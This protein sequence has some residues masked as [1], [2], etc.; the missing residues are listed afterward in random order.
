MNVYTSIPESLNTSNSVI[1]MGGFDGVH[2]GHQCIIQLMKKK[3]SAIQ[4]ETIVITFEPHPRLVLEPNDTDFKLLTIQEEKIELF[5]QHGID[6]LIFLPF[7]KEFAQTSSKEFVQ[8]ILVDKLQVKELVIGFNHRF[9]IYREGNFN[10]LVDFGKQFGFNVSEVTACQIESNTI[11]STKI[12]K[13]IN[14]SEIEKTNT[15]L[16]YPYFITGRVVLGNQ[17]GRG[18]NYPTANIKVNPLKLIPSTGVYASRTEINGILY[19]SMTYIGTRPT[20]D[21]K[22]P[23]I[24]THIFDFNED[25][26]GKDIKI[27]FLT[28]T[29]NQIRFNNTD[30]LKIQLEKDKIQILALL[31]T[32]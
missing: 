26:Y 18:L 28:K 22:K 31:H 25:L 19:K 8:K 6:H 11:S 27:Q 4:G 29:R 16:G 5:K 10:K 2:L 15:W 21:T 1:T 13:A 12:R 23:T 32:L 30:E 20:L 9:G 24:E 14:N 7:T 17:I 3:A